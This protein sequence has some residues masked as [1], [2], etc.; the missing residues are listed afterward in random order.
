MATTMDGRLRGWGGW[1][2]GSWWALLLSTAKEKGAVESTDC[3]EPLILKANN[4][5]EMTQQGWSV[6]RRA[7]GAL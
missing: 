5:R 1:A 7:M 3:P 6:C 2:R 4:K